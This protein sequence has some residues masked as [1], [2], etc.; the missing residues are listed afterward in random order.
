MK[1]QNPFKADFQITQKFGNKSN[2][3]LSGY[4][5]GT[6]FL[7][8][9]ANHKPYPAEIFPICDGSEIFYN[10][11]SIIFGKS[12]KERAELDQDL[13]TYLKNRGVVPREHVGTVQAEIFY[14]HM[15]KVLDKDGTV[16]QDTPIGLAGNT[17]YVFTTDKNGN[18]IEV[19]ND[20]KGVPPYPGLHTH[21]ECALRSGN[22]V[23]NVDKD[24]NPNG[25]IDVEILLD[26]MKGK[27]MNQAKVVKSKFSNT[28]YICYPVSSQ[29]YLKEKAS[30]EGIMIP[31]QIPTTDSLM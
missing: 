3:Y 31:D 29:E 26:Y 15:L 6:D 13:I 18:V 27:Y 12:V 23:F 11:E 1:L 5:E 28:V 19:P 8:L 21:I 10:D 4:H 22:K 25:V 20:Q 2:R 24:K 9:D 17:G 16:T 7:P 30:L 14:G